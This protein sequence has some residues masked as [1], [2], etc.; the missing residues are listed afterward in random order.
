MKTIASLVAK[1]MTID[2]FVDPR[3]KT[4]DAV[5]IGFDADIA[6]GAATRT[7]GG[8]FLQIP[9]ANFE[10]EIAV[11]QRA[12]WTDINDVSGKR[13]IENHIREHRN[14]GMIAAID[15][16]KFVGPGNLLKKAYA[17]RTFDAAL[18]VKYNVGTEDFPL[19]IV[20][21]SLLKAA[22]LT[23]VLHV[24]VLQPT[25]PRLV[26]DRTIQRVLYQKKLHHRSA[27]RQHFRALGQ[28]RHPFCRLGVTSDLELRHFRDLD[29]THAA[30][31]R[32]GKLRMIAVVRDVDAYVRRRLDDGLPLGA[33]NFLAV[34]SE[35]NWI[36][37]LENV[38]SHKTEDGG[39][40]IEDGVKKSII[41]P[42]SSIFIQLITVHRFCAMCASNSSRY[43]LIKAAAGIAAASP[44]G[45][46]VLPIMLP[47]TLRIR[48][49]S[50]SS[51]SPCS[52]R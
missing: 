34:N 11:R 26:T 16:R 21:F 17:A 44:N 2:R 25:L 33:A 27:N 50:S 48:S 40:S 13:I 29:E 10:A 49:R 46:I 45:Q 52:M 42:L 19:A 7:D 51:P 31:T 36:H 28:D 41:D 4:S 6:A 18:A 12:H 22:R 20:L 14:G 47:L 8:R 37:N 43:F 9:N 35:L 15:H 3:L 32:D 30:V 5:L 23:V 1:P 38:A 24:I 39:S